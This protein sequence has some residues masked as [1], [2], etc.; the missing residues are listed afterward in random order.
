MT[1]SG[2]TD[3]DA[4]GDRTPLIE[5]TITPVSYTGARELPTADESNSSAADAEPPSKARNK[6]STKIV[7]RNALLAILI[8]ALLVVIVKGYVDSD[9]V[10]VRAS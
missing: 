4:K 8:A 6:I 2:E 3:P 10:D 9:D 1:A 5:P 7:V